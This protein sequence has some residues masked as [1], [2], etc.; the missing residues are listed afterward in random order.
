[1]NVAPSHYFGG[2]EILDSTCTETTKIQDKHFKLSFKMY[3]SFKE[4]IELWE[5]REY[6]SKIKMISP[7]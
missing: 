2:L 7:P 6:Q 1:M 3:Q 4:S 5:G